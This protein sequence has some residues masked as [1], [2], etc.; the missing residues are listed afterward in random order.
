MF[1][2]CR[3]R[4]SQLIGI[5]SSFLLKPY[6]YPQ[7]QMVAVGPVTLLGQRLGCVSFPPF[8]TYIPPSL[9]NIYHHTAGATMAISD[10]RAAHHIALEVEGSLR[11]VA[12]TG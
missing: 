5:H 12:D 4:W 2:V 1:H 3:L 10:E 11:G 8:A 9:A 7:Q 6:P